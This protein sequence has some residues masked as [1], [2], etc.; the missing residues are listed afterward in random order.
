MYRVYNAFT[1]IFCLLAIPS[2]AQESLILKDSL[3]SHVEE[4]AS[5]AYQG[6]ATETEGN[7]RAQEYIL[8]RYEAIGLQQFDSSYVHP[9]Q[10]FNRF[11]RKAYQGQNLLGYIPGTEQPELF[12]V[13]SAHFDHVGVKKG[14]V[15]NGADDNASGVGALLE[16]ARYLA[17][18]PL[19][20]S[21]IIAA[22]D[23]EEVGLR[24]ADAFTDEPPV[25]INR[26]RL[27]INMDMISRNDNNEIYICGTSYYPALR[28][29]L[30]KLAEQAPIKVSFGH[31]A[32]ESAG[33]NDWTNASDHYKFHQKDIPFLYFGVED[34]EDYHK[35]EDDFE[36]IM[37]DFYHRVAE[38]ILRSAQALDKLE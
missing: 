2:V 18:H 28:P 6:R 38:L 12:I 1:L 31:E 8:K 34:H 23:A 20:H 16:I 4:L 26:I 22:F 29:A 36:R 9:F 21:L 35:P 10:F 33:V 30:D 14:V 3:L 19:K 11:T 25:P 13:L 7:R 15:Y 32:P 27:N 37:P 24:G 5:D 17:E